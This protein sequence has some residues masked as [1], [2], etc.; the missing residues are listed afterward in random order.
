[1][2]NVILS[3]IGSYIPSSQPTYN[4]SNCVEGIESKNI[5]SASS[6]LVV[7]DGLAERFEL[8]AE[9]LVDEIKKAS[10]FKTGGEFLSLFLSDPVAERT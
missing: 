8:E 9:K 5:F 2:T 4:G 10:S 1:M 6:K 7:N 3:G